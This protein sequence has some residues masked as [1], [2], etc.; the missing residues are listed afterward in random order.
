MKVKTSIQG[1]K[2]PGSGTVDPPIPYGDDTPPPIPF[3]VP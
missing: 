2:K 3:P 1:G